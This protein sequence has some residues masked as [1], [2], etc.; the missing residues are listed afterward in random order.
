MVAVKAAL[1]NGFTII[2]CIDPYPSELLLQYIPILEVI[3]QP[4]QQ[5]PFSEFEALEPND[6]LFVDGTHVCKIGSDVNY[7]VLEVLPCLKPGV[8]IHFHDIFL[9]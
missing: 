5:I 9:P 4:V 1:R 8:L 2:K 6:I 7:I 3:P